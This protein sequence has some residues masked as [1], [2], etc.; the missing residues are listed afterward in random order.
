MAEEAGALRALEH[1][2][3]AAL[4]RQFKTQLEAIEKLRRAVE[5]A[6]WLAPDVMRKHGVSLDGADLRDLDLR[7]VDLRGVPMRG[8]DL[9]GADLRGADV[10][11]ADLRGA[12]L[13]GAKADALRA[14]KT[15]LRGAKAS[16]MT[17]RGARFD[18]A[19]LDEADLRNARA[20][21]ASFRNASTDRTDFRG[22]EMATADVAGATID[23]ADTRGVAMDRTRGWLAGPGLPVPS[24]SE[25]AKDPEPVE[26]K[27]PA[28]AVPAQ[29]ALFPP[30]VMAKLSQS[31]EPDVTQTSA[32]AQAYLAMLTQTIEPA[33]VKTPQLAH[34]IGR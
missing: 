16:S 27:P 18:G 15:D 5:H 21:G 11:G 8:A 17:A 31:A 3:R 20:Y 1:A 30:M 14:E 28:Q 29:P 32:S 12:D 4:E 2:A 19:V 23:Q 25:K 6:E 26:A 10:S 7:G 13:S 9:R 24:A 33:K 34:D 22:A